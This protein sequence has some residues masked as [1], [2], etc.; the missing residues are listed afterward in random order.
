MELSPQ[1]AQQALDAI[2]SMMNKARRAVSNSGAYAFLFIWGVVWLFGFSANHFLSGE[3][4]GYVW[5]VLD[6]LG[7]ILSAVMGVRMGKKIR[8]AS[9][10]QTGRRIGW[11]WLLLAVY[12]GLLLLVTSPSDLKQGSLIIVIFVMIGW[13]AMGLLLSTASVWGA[14][15]IT[16]LALVGYYLLPGIFFLWMAV[17]GGGGMIALGFFIRKR[18]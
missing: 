9:G 3:N 2:E 8:S 10:A 6:T 7:G 18:W 1:E 14:L 16:A 15:A 5:M 17:L 11:F 4:V 13:I 12:C